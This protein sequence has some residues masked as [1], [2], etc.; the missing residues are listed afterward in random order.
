MGFPAPTLRIIDEASGVPVNLSS[1]KPNVVEYAVQEVDCGHRGWYRCQMEH[2]IAGDV[3]VKMTHV[4]IVTCK[5]SV[6]LIIEINLDLNM[7]RRGTS[8]GK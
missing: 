2:A 7:L 3:H 5:Y 1:S 6:E 8:V 4:E